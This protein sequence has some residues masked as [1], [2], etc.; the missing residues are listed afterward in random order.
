MDAKKI[1][2]ICEK[3]D[4]QLRKNETVDI[5]AEIDKILNE[6]DIVCEYLRS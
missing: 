5:S 1:F 3:L 6:L 4:I 2:S